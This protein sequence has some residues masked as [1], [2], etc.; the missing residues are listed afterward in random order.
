[1]T[2]F[3]QK[4]AEFFEF[5]DFYFILSH[6]I[7]SLLA[8][9]DFPTWATFMTSEDYDFTMQEQKYCKSLLF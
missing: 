6:T 9:S 3:S 8:K 1:M 4:L 5:A 2:S 7:R